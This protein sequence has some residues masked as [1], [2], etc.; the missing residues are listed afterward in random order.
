MWIFHDLLAISFSVMHSYT[1]DYYVVF[2]DSCLTPVVE[3]SFEFCLKENLKDF[4]QT[5]SH[6]HFR[7]VSKTIVYCK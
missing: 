1:Q 2:F 4:C 5:Q 6:V 7:D 3:K